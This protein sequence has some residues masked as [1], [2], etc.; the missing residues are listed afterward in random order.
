MTSRNLKMY[1]SKMPSDADAVRIYVLTKAEEILYFHTCL[2]PPE[3]NPHQTV[4][5]A[6]GLAFV[7][8]DLRH[9][10]ATRYYQ[11]NKDVVK[12]VLGHSNLRTVMKYVHV[13]QEHRDE[14]TRAYE[15][16]LDQFGANTNAKNLESELTG[17]NEASDACRRI[18]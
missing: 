8:Y 11:A 13:S 10:F 18:Q 17:D 12:E 2:R 1:G 4:L 7:L 16:T 14:A 6:T 5:E 15:A 9:T 3:E